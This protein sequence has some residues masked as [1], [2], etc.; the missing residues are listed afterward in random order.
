[1]HNRL[2]LTVSLAV[3]LVLNKNEPNQMYCIK[4]EIQKPD[5]RLVGRLT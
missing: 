1:L 3:V 2:S 4:C 5:S